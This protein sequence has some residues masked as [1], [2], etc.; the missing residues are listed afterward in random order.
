M[1]RGNQRSL[2]RL[3]NHNTEGLQERRNTQRRSRS[4]GRPSSKSGRPKEGERHRT[5]S[6]SRSRSPR[7]RHGSVSSVVVHPAQERHEPE[8][9]TKET[10]PP[11]RVKSL[12]EAQEGA[13]YV[14]KKLEAE[15]RKS[16]RKKKSQDAFRKQK[17]KSSKTIYEEQYD[18]NIEIYNKLEQATNIEDAEERNTLLDEGMELI[19]QRNKVSVLTDTYDWEKAMCYGTDPVASDSEDEK[20][21]KRARKDA[22]VAKEEKSKSKNLRLKP[23]AAGRSK[24]SFRNYYKGTQNSQPSPISKQV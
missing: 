7:S 2:D 16:E 12:L 3:K 1:P 22:K 23:A 14:W 11:T 17:H 24:K 6:R 4:S 19:S 18:L 21:I 9:K 15:I 10:S 20:R 13:S 5:K 8:D